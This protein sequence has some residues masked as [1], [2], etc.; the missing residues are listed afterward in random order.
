MNPTF[1]IWKKET[2]G[3]FFQPTFYVIAFFLAT[4]FSYLFPIQLNL[5]SQLATN[6]VAQ[7][8]VPQNQLNIHYGVFLRHLS[9][10]NLL[11]IIIVPAFTMKL[12]AEEKKLKTFDL[13]LTSPLTSFQIV[14]GK[15]LSVLTVI[16]ALVVIGFLYPAATG[17]VADLQWGP[18]VIAFLSLF[19]V[20]AVYAAMDLFCSSLTESILISYAMSVML[21]VS[22]W[23]IGIGAEV[24]D[25][26][27]ARNIFEHISL[28]NH[29]AGLVEGTVRT[30][31]L[32]FFFSL[33]SMFVFLAERVVES[34]RWRST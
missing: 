34:T 16:F 6:Y 23:F 27:T 9:T 4:I 31:A 17:F 10:I 11:F 20:G 25:T 18:L 33:I 13:L 12:L 14:F 22:I 5:F 2:K 24:V 21:N 8:G 19:L 1:V 29:L 30:S 28:N 32:I 15:Y 26:Q 3:F 7:Q